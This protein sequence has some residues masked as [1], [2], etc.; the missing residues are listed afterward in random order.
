MACP[1][2]GRDTLVQR[3][4]FALRATRLLAMLATCAATSVSAQSVE[5]F[6]PQG[7]VKGVRQ[8][9]ARFAVPM[10]AFGDPR[11]LDP[12]EIDCAVKGRGRWADMRNWVYDFDQDLPAGVRCSF[13]VKSGLTAVDGSA[14]VAGQ[15]FDFSTGGPSIL[16]SLPYEGTGIDENQIFVLG[17]DAPATPASIMASAYC[18]AAGIHE[19]IGVRLVTG[20]ER[21]VILDHRKS[22]AS[23]YLRFVLINADT[24]RSRA[25]AF[26]LPASGSDDDTF[27]RLR[28]APDSPL[29]TLACA[30]TL[31]AGAE[32]KLVWGK[33][34]ATSNGVATTDD[35]ALAFE[36]RPAFRATFRCERVNRN[37]Q[38]LSLIP[39]TLSFTAPVARR[40]A[41]SGV[42][43]ARPGLSIVPPIA[44][45]IF[46]SRLRTVTGS[47]G[48]APPGSLLS[49]MP[50][51][52]GNL[53]S[54]GSSSVCTLSGKLAALVSTRP[55]SS[56][57]LAGI[58]SRN[59]IFSGRP[60]PNVTA[61]IASTSCPFGS[62]AG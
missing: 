7:T 37:A 55:A 13:T 35:Q 43:A 32:M 24:G 36:V 33:G 52:P 10:V 1:R 50:K 54:G 4:A 5:L 62:F 12:F 59:A 26:A 2:Q 27:R 9:S 30:R 61:S 19:R 40:D 29:V 49:R 46:G 39:L 21:K 22:F 14:V 6:S 51:S 45:A 60:G 47:S 11:E 48:F 38:C 56:L 58:S 25:F 57:R 28:D 53:A 20:D 41:A 17:L 34:I 15:R 8:A 16:R 42:G 44:P 31:P 3:I 18:V 23:S